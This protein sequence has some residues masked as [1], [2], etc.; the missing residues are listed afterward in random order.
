MRQMIKV[1]VDSHGHIVIPSEFKSSLKLSPGSTLVVEEGN[2]G[3]VC[4][5]ARI[6]LPK[7]AYKQGV[8]IVKAKPIRDL[9]N[10]TRL[11]RNRRISALLQRV[12]L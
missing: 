4:L 8:L 5:C 3:A 11:E 7:L 12:S 10:I 2:K 1:F 6:D 9:R